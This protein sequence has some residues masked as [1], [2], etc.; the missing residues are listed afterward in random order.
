MRIF[1]LIAGVLLISG[2]CGCSS[3]Q[4]YESGQTWQRNRCNQIFDAQERIRC[5]ES[6]STSFE[7]YQRE[8][9]AA[10]NAR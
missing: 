7:E 10:R 4:L 9:E 8:S 3:Q 1:C 6:T 5:L 2:L